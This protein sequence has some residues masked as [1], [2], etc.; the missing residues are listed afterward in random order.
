MRRSTLP[1]AT[2]VV[3]AVI[4]THLPIAANA[5]TACMGD[6]NSKTAGAINAAIFLMLGFISLMLGSFVAFAYYLSRRAT[7]GSS[8]P[9]TGPSD[10]TDPTDALS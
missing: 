1:A 9:D 2:S 10:D 3:L 7:A 5:C 4:L 8:V 6:P